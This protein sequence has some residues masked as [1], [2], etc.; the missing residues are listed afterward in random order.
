MVERIDGGGV[1]LPKRVETPKKEK[2]EKLSSQGVREF[3]LQSNAF[4]DV[5]N[6]AEEL[7]SR[8]VSVSEEMD[9]SLG[10]LSRYQTA[11]QSYSEIKNIVDG[12]REMQFEYSP[13]E[14]PPDIEAAFQEMT[15]NLSE[16]V[17]SATFEGSPVFTP[18]EALTN[19]MNAES[20]ELAWPYVEPATV[21]IEGFGR[22]TS[23]QLAA[24]STR[25]A[26]AQVAYENLV[27][28]STPG[29]VSEVADLLS[30][31]D[32]SVSFEGMDLNRTNII[33]ILGT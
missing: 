16:A 26:E 29:N 12:I 20:L 19:V 2:L 1:N 13:G 24:V 11:K 27:S 10:E 30:A 9:T 15:A 3:E 33:Q 17:S 22:E 28:A 25:V 32:S 18:G 14:I 21:E 7:R 6:V 23:E 4:S 5:A 31:G 8:L